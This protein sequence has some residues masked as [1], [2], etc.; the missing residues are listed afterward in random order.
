MWG[1]PTLLHLEGASGPYRCGTARALGG[2]LVGT[3]AVGLGGGGAGSIGRLCRIFHEFRIAFDVAKSFNGINIRFYV[4]SGLLYRFLL[5]HVTYACNCVF[6]DR[7]MVSVRLVIS[8]AH[9]TPNLLF[10]IPMYFHNTI[11]DLFPC[12]F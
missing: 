4:L 1:P 8:K 5:D 10:G 6:N 7:E 2:G 3:G 11:V 9:H 12:L